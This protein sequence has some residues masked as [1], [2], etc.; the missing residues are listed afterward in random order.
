MSGLAERMGTC[1]LVK[2]SKYYEL[3]N[4]RLLMAFKIKRRHDVII[5]ETVL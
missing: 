2:T 3:S 5:D 1:K 4:R